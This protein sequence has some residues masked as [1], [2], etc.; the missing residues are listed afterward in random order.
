MEDME[1][2]N[3]Y[4]FVED[5]QKEEGGPPKNNLLK[6]IIKGFVALLLV[7]LLVYFSGPRQ[8][9]FFRRTDPDLEIQKMEKVF[10]F[11]TVA[12]PVVA[13]VV[14]EETRGSKRNEKEIV[15]LL[16]N[17]SKILHQAGILL[18]MDSFIEVELTQNEAREVL[19]GDFSSINQ[20]DKGKINL[21][22]VKTLG[23]LN[24][25]AYP[26]KNTTIIPDYTAGVDFRV[27]AHEVGH[28]LGLGHQEEGKYLMSQ[29]ATG[30]LISKEEVIKMRKVLYEKF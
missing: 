19:R 9:Y 30:N 15:S 25:V 5:N 3:E 4:Y 7:L 22:L 16:K 11:E 29:G 24:G 28:I 6:N 13:L 8:F 23:G 18:D 26:G 14:R 17:S 2:K 12:V 10:D 20:L 1:E 21:I 27:L